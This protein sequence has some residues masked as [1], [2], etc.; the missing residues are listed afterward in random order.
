MPTLT[1]AENITL[2]ADLAGTK[3]DKQW[4]EFL[5]DKI[6]IAG[7][8]THRPGELSGGQQQPVACARALMN[9]PNLVLPTSPPVTST[10]TGPANYWGSCAGPSTSWAN[11][12]SW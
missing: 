4:F 8:L 11:R 6:G 12:S 2:P 5:V 1:A 7:R 3:V 10:R 9:K